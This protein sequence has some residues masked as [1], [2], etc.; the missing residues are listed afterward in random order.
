MVITQ[1]LHSRSLKS[2]SGRRQA[3]VAM[4]QTKPL[5]GQYPHCGATAEKLAY[6]RNPEIGRL[7]GDQSFIRRLQAIIELSGKSL[8]VRVRQNRIMIA[9]HE[10]D[11]YRLRG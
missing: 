8:H 6:W 11:I 7:Q 9:R 4:I 1:A 10:M 5:T 3:W 2:L